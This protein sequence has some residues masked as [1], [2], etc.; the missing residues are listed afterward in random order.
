MYELLEKITDGRGT[1]ADLKLLKDLALVIKDTSLCGL[2]QTAPNPVLST[3]DNFWDEYEAHVKERRC[4]S[5]ACKSLVSYYVV[6]D[7][8]KGC[9][10]CAR[11]CPAEAI[12][13]KVKEPHVIDQE[14]CVKCGAC[15][16]ACKFGAIIKK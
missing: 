10:L 6:A 14:K 16:T 2:G 3:L 1:E 12:S 11:A 9:T 7:Q 4:P 8:C 13:G 15:M 5:G